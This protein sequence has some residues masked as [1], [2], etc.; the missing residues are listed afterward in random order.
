MG[1]ALSSSY[2]Y[3]YAPANTGTVFL[4][5]TYSGGLNRLAPLAGGTLL[6]NDNTT[7]GTLSIAGGGYFATGSSSFGP[8][9]LVARRRHARRH[10]AADRQ[11]CHWQR[12]DLDHHRRR[13]P[14]A[15]LW[16][17]FQPEVERF[18]CLTSGTTTIS[19]PG[20]VGTLSGLISGSRRT[21]PLRQ[22][23]Q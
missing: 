16:R 10:H 5:G 19:D 3:T 14:Q 13:G 22:H 18:A 21:D 6:I 15:L 23:W 4:S 8:H 2:S 9:H 17:Q 12:P 7:S 11:Q 1:G 20:G